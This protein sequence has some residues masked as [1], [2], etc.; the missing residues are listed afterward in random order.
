VGAEILH[1]RRQR[2]V[3]V[4][5]LADSEPVTGHVDPTA[6]ARLVGVHRDQVRAF[7]GRQQGWGPGVA[8]FP[9]RAFEGGD[10]LRVAQRPRAQSRGEAIA[11]EQ[12]EILIFP[13]R[14]RPVQGA[15][16]WYRAAMRHGVSRVLRGTRDTLGVIFHDAK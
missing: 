14:Y 7:V 11:P 13:T 8:P 15:R 6:E 5:V 2:R 1:E 3:E 16:G 9:Q 4:L 10:F 12:G